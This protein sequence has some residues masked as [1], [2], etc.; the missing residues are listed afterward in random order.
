MNLGVDLG[1]SYTK[2]ATCSGDRRAEA[3]R[4]EVAEPDGVIPVAVAYGGGEAVVGRSAFAAVTRPAT[5]LHEHF[6][7]RLDRVPGGSPPVRTPAAVTRDYVD[8]IL[9]SARTSGTI[10]RLDT[11]VVAVPPRWLATGPP[12]ELLRVILTEDLG[13]SRVRLIGQHVAAATYLAQRHEGGHL[14]LCDVGACRVTVTLCAVD[15]QT[16]RVIDSTGSDDEHPADHAGLEIEAALADSV[17]LRR[18]LTDALYHRRSPSWLAE[19]LDDRHQPTHADVA[20]YADDHHRVEVAR[21]LAA[22]RPLIDLIGHTIARFRARNPG[23]Q[24]GGAWRLAVLGGASLFPPVRAAVH[25]AFGIATGTR[26]GLLLDLSAEEVM[27]ATAMGAAFV[28]EG[29]AEPGDRFPH[30]VT[31]PARRVQDGRLRAAH[32]MVAGPGELRAGA[33]D[34]MFAA[35]PIRFLPDG[36]PLLLDVHRGDE[37][38]R[39][40]VPHHAR[41]ESGDFDVGLLMAGDGVLHLVFRPIGDAQ[42]RPPYPLGDLREKA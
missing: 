42:D 30:R 3:V 8:G 38:E 5:T 21:A 6:T 41:P 4:L 35:A 33:L 28:A 16:V 12:A 20:L 39:I 29:L 9:R 27:Y 7:P 1:T 18:A 13:L 36:L 31:L 17:P 11:L 25:Q 24:P 2:L 19:V 14:V 37:P 40:T 23:L 22:T 10:R 32:L 26:L 15:G 34:P